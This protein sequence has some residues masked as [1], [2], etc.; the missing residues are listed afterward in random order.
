MILYVFLQKQK[1]KI[2]FFS[3]FVKYPHSHTLFI[4]VSLIS[5]DSVGEEPL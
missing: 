2:N 4:I 5:T 1:I 3:I